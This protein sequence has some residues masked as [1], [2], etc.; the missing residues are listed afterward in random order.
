MGGGSLICQKWYCC[1]EMGVLW[2]WK[3]CGDMGWL[4][5]TSQPISCVRRLVTRPHPV[6][7]L[8]R[9]TVSGMLSDGWLPGRLMNG[10][11]SNTWWSQV[12]TLADLFQCVVGSK[13]F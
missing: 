10:L 3:T 4:V 2:W 5:C 7:G 9:A 8:L 11:S 12:N 13:V 6:D 1:V